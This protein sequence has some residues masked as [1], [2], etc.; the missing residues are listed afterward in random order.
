MKNFAKLLIVVLLISSFVPVASAATLDELNAKRIDLIE[1]LISVLEA[2]VAELT[3][4]LNAQIASQNATSTPV[5]G[6]VSNNTVES[7]N[8]TVT[9]THGSGS[10]DEYWKKCKVDVKPESC[11]DRFLDGMTKFVINEPYKKAT[12]E[13]HITGKSTEPVMDLAPDGV[14]GYFLPNTEYTYNLMITDAAGK[15]S[16]VSGTFTTENY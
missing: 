8:Y 2:K 14:H 16:H 13:Y 6:S 3:A 5:F 4:Q 10:W 9:I 7:T 1:Q 15:E 12:I 11:A